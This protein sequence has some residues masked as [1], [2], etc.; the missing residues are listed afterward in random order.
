MTTVN[1][2]IL[3]PYKGERVVIVCHQVNC[4]GVMGAGLAKQVKLKHP[5]VYQLYKE[6]CKL[7]ADGVGGLGDVQFCSTSS[8]YIVA[9]IFAQ[10]SYGYSGQYTDYDALRK[11]FSYISSSYPN[12]IIRIP[13]K[14]G[15]GYGGGNWSV[16]SKIIEDAFGLNSRNVEIWMLP[17]AVVT[18]L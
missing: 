3:T 14:I 10:N 8:G 11:A 17:K 6:K 16:V 7:I 5:V 4:K 13:Y 2:N 12:A 1:G 15:C 9:N 18:N